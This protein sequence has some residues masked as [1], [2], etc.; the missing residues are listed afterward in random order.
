MKLNGAL[1]PKLAESRPFA[2]GTFLVVQECERTL[3]FNLELQ[4]LG[5]GLSV[6]W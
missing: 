4:G 1:R 6:G 3:A 2:S 5:R